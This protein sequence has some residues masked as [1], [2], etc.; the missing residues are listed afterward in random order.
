MFK[1]IQRLI[2]EIGDPQWFLSFQFYLF[3]IFLDLTKNK[4]P[5]SFFWIISE[6]SSEVTA[7]HAMSNSFSYSFY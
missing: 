4:I 1:Q 7:R 3:Q 2:I 6:V 5:L